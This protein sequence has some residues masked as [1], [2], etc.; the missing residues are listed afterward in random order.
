MSIKTANEILEELSV[1]ENPVTVSSLKTIAIS[2]L[3]DERDCL[4][5]A[6]KDI[7][8]LCE[9]DNDEPEECSWARAAIDKVEGGSA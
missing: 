9:C 4:L 5:A 3:K 8:P 6:L 1:C 2:K 7:L